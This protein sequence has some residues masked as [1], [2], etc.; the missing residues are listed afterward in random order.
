[1]NPFAWV[2]APRY[3]T[4]GFVGLG[5]NEVPA[6]LERGERV[7]SRAELRALASGKAGGG[8]SSAPAN[9]NFKNVN[10]FDAADLLSAA[11]ATEVGQ[12]VF[13]NHVRSNRTS[14][15]AALGTKG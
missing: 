6:I 14:V 2:G 7:Q 8:G 4:G 10:L 11:L 5:P 3:H 9:V 12:K 13:I 15:N 1:M